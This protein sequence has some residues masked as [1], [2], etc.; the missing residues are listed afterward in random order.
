MQAPNPSSFTSHIFTTSLS[1]THMHAHDYITNMFTT[2]S[3][4]FINTSSHITTT[5]SVHTTICIFSAYT[6]H[7]LTNVTMPLF[8]LITTFTTSLYTC[9]HFFGQDSHI[10]SHHFTITPLSHHHFTTISLIH[11]HTFKVKHSPPT[12]ICIHTTTSP[13]LLHTPSHTHSHTSWPP[14]LINIDPHS[15][16]LTTS[17]PHLHTPTLTI[18]LLG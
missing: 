15:Y 9:M 8:Y 4:H 3:S 7:H 13:T 16:P 1:H 2:P 12:H 11:T 10:P 18:G 17:L 5:Q 14:Q 6:H